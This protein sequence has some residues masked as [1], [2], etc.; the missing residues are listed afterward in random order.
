MV[1]SGVGCPQPRMVNNKSPYENI[2]NRHFCLAMRVC[3][4]TALLIGHY[5][6]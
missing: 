6:F 2:F 3:G 4:E 5:L 1:L